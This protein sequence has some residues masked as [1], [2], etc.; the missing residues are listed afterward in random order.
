LFVCS[1]V[2]NNLFPESLIFLFCRFITLCIFFTLAIV[3][4]PAE[5]YNCVDKDGNSFITD[6]PPED[7]KCKSTGE[8]DKS[9]SQQQQ[10]DEVQQSEQNDENNRQKGEIKRLIKIPRLSY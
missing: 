7:A 6:N 4:H 2:R 8:V 1:E 10:N 5:F 3:A 9:A